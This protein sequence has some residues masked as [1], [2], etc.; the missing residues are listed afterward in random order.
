MGNALAATAAI[1]AGVESHAVVGDDLLAGAIDGSRA[2][3]VGELVGHIV[4]DEFA[5]QP[6]PVTG[7]TG[8]VGE[9]TRKESLMIEVVCELGA[10]QFFPRFGSVVLS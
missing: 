7:E 4:E 3:V 5:D 8:K 2:F 6:A 9:F 1:E 10:L